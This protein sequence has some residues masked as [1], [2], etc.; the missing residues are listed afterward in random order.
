MPAA[1]AGAGPSVSSATQ[2]SVFRSSKLEPPGADAHA[3]ICARRDL[4]RSGIRHQ[5]LRF[6][7]VMIETLR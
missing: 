5:R 6:Q 4:W 7:A 3:T 2:M 1:A